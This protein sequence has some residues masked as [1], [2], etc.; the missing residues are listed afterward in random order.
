MDRVLAN[1]MMHNSYLQS[2]SAAVLFTYISTSDQCLSS[3]ARLLDMFASCHWC[4]EKP[5]R[6]GKPARTDNSSLC[7]NAHALLTSKEVLAGTGI[8]RRVYSRYWPHMRTMI[9]GRVAP[10]NLGGS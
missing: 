5:G 9:T 1:G 3:Y 4:L 8:C 7:M 2:F 6:R 10:F